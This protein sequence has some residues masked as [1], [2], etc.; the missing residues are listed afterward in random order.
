MNYMIKAVKRFNKTMSICEDLNVLK[1]ND[2]GIF[3]HDDFKPTS[4]DDLIKETK[5]QISLYYENGHVLNDLRYE[6]YKEWNRRVQMLK[7]LLN[8]LNDFKKT[9]E[10]KKF[11]ERLEQTIN[12][13]F[14]NKNENI[15]LDSEGNKLY[16]IREYDWVF[17]PWDKKHNNFNWWQ[18]ITPELVDE[19][20][21]E[22]NKLRNG[23][24]L[25]YYDLFKEWAKKELKEVAKKIEEETRQGKNPLSEAT[26]KRLLGC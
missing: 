21:D 22:N 9:E 18:T 4:I 7:R 19:L 15:I 3:E 23:L 16:Y 14:Q 5:Y 8:T 11:C 17:A 2:D 24:K 26:L 25:G 13:Y 1:I 6:S 20:F 10:H 12:V